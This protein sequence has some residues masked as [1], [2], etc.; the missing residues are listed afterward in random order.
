MEVVV[1]FTPQPLYSQG[2][3]PWYPMNAVVRRKIPSPYR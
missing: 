3:S 1:S 2:K